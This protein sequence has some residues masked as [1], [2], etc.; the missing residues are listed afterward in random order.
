MEEEDKQ[1]HSSIKDHEILENLEFDQIDQGA[2]EVEP[3]EIAVVSPSS[4]SLCEGL[5]DDFMTNFKDFDGFTDLEGTYE[6][7][8]TEFKEMYIK[9]KQ[10]QLAA[11]NDAAPERIGG[12]P[13]FMQRE[14]YQEVLAQID[15]VL[16]PHQSMSEYS[17]MTRD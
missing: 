13:P 16:E 15:K 9:K 5:M 11:A 10:S 2:D 3:P 6:L 8:Y 14:N 17:K 12:L 4:S 7:T 1:N